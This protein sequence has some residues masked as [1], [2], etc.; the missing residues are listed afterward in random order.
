MNYQTN[1]NKKLK[2]ELD[3][4]KEMEEKMK[5]EA[6]DIVNRLNLLLFSKKND[7]NFATIDVFFIIKFYL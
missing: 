6:F 4:L 1:C 3:K 7:W 2:I 5:Q